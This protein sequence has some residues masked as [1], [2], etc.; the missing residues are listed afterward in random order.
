MAAQRG[1]VQ[2]VRNYHETGWCASINFFSHFRGLSRGK[3][4]PNVWMVFERSSLEIASDLY[5]QVL[6]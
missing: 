6:M 5:L 3:F 1:L 2:T 4:H